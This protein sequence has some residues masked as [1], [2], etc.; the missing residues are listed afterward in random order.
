MGLA[1]VVCI[2]APREWAEGEEGGSRVSGV[3]ITFFSPGPKMKSSCLSG[4]GLAISS[5]GLDGRRELKLCLMS[6][7]VTIL[8]RSDKGSGDLERPWSASLPGSAILAEVAT[9]SAREGK[10]Q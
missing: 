3:T 1:S 4:G 2:G 7:V 5:I 10:L 6:S 8:F 9:R